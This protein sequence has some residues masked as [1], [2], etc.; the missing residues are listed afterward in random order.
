VIYCSLSTQTSTK[1]MRKG[2]LLFVVYTKM[3]KE[4]EELR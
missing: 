2:D 3:C 4:H 1:N